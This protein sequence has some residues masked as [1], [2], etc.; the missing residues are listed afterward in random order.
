MSPK[1]KVAR[2]E[3]IGVN[4]KPNTI[5]VAYELWYPM[6]QAEKEKCRA[7]GY[8]VG[9]R[10]MRKAVLAEIDEIRHECL[11]ADIKT[12]RRRISRL[13]IEKLK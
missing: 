6:I 13:K 9:Q 3:L 2:P 8:E 12:F 10:A 5:T 4:Q 7:E 1:G 11:C